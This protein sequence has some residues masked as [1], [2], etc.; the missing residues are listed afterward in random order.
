MLVYQPDCVLSWI[1]ATLNQRHPVINVPGI[2]YRRE[3]GFIVVQAQPAR[4]VL[5][6]LDHLRGWQGDQS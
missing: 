2:T 6:T 3:R 1:L 4:F 5:E